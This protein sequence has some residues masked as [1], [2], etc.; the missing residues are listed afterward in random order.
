[1]ESGDRVAESGVEGVLLHSV[2]DRSCTEVSYRDVCVPV[3]VCVN[4]CIHICF[5][6]SYVYIRE[7]SEGEITQP[8]L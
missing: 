1:M 3:C 4:E 7:S 8:S 5:I 2:Y 6:C